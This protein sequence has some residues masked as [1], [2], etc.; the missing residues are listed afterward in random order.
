VSPRFDIRLARTEDLAAI[1]AIYNHEVEHTSA[2]F[3]TEPVTI[4]ERRRWLDDHPPSRH[5][6]VVAEAGGAIAGWASLSRWSSKRAY[7][8]TA[9]VSVYVHRDHRGR[10]VGK[11]LLLDLVERGRAAGL[12][13]ILTRICTA[14]G[15]AS[16]RLHEAVGFQRIG[17]LR[18]CGQK[19]G[20]LLDVELL[21]LHLD[22]H[23]AR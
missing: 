1:A 7:D 8:R 15:P 6:V 21:D 12:G 9:E 5:P 20:R 19:H 13:V 14:D 18:R 22:A 23:A 17:T 10:G 11:A 2:T 4:E 3:D 16:L